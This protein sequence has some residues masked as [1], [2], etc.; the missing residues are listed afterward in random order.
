MK[1]LFL[2]SH[3]ELHITHL[4][5]SWRKLG[6]ECDVVDS[7]SPEALKKIILDNNFDAV[8]THNLYFFDELRS[9][10]QDLELVFREMNKPIFVWF[11][12]S[13]FSSGR[14]QRINEHVF[15]PYPQHLI[16]LVTD[17]GWIPALTERG[18]RA[19]Y[20]PLAVDAS[21]L[22]RKPS[23][24]SSFRNKVAFVGKPW[25]DVH[26]AIDT[27]TKRKD[28][29]HGVFLSELKALVLEKQGALGLENRWVETG[30]EL[31][32]RQIHPV[33][34]TMNAPV[35]D[36]R[37][38]FDAFMARIRGKVPA[39]FY[40]LIL[41]LAGRVDM[42][43]SYGQMSDYLSEL[44]PLGL[45]VYGSTKWNWHLGE[46]AS[47]SS[48]WLSQ[49]ELDDCFSSAGVSFCYTKQQFIN[50]I[51]ERP[52]LIFGSGGFAVTDDKQDLTESYGD[53]PSFVYTCKEE[54]KE[55]VSFFLMNSR[56]REKVQA[57]CRQ[58]VQN[59]M[60]YDSRALDL[61]NVLKG[62]L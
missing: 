48:R 57:Q 5:N 61:M 59:R 37:R 16:H 50:G 33:F 12:D 45:E 10:G 29:F 30:L 58:W 17:S 31:I 38:A 19:H 22:E 35:R 49:K 32:D 9:C 27:T 46:A 47:K 4:A 13:P 7:H 51:H 24:R 23:E 39:G 14:M 41:L 8:L 60:T 21:V 3:Q 1:I 54:A 42:I 52:I 55:K 44:Q 43:F 2:R 28:F 62:Y 20:F 18:L 15:G 34:D 40:R 56:E 53:Q 6:H 25:E 26:Q 36:Y 11:L